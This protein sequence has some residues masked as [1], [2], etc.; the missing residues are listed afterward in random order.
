MRSFVVCTC[1]LRDDLPAL[2]LL[3][4]DFDAYAGQHITLPVN[5][6]VTSNNE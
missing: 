4:V 5:T 3:T 1:S 6:T 2:F